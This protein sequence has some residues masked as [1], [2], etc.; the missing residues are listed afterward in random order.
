MVGW[1]ANAIQVGI[2]MYRKRAGVHAMGELTEAEQFI[3]TWDEEHLTTK[4][5]RVTPSRSSSSSASRG[6]PEDL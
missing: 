5:R 2:N 6:S 3:K 1:F 4:S